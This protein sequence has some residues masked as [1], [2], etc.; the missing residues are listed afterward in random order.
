[1]CLRIWGQSIGFW[2]VKIMCDQVECKIF[3]SQSTYIDTIT[4]CFGLTD[5]KPQLT[6]MLPNAVYLKDDSPSDLTHAPRMKKVPYRETVSY[7]IY[8]AVATHPNISFTILTLS[9]FLENPGEHYWDAVK[10]I[11]HYLSGTHNLQLTFNSNHHN[12]YGYTD[13]DGTSQLY[14]HTISGYMFLI[15]GAAV[16]WS[17]HKQEL[18]TLSTAEVEYVAV[19]HTAKEVVWLHCVIG[20][21]FSSSST[22]TM[23]LCNNQAAIKLMID[24]NYH[25]CTKHIDICYHF[26]HQ[27]ISAGEIE[28]SYCLMEDMTAD[29]LTKALLVWKVAQHIAGLSLHNSMVTLMGECW[30]VWDAEGRRDCEGCRN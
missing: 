28:I 13:I 6:P 7:L 14:Q 4:T 15:D 20:E 8:V 22:L 21:L 19:I 29:V 24:D 30:N 3:L 17:S 9:Q 2:G 12:L 10:R 25:A 27:V 11:F 26:I 23:L 18:V 1:M 16:S 5:A